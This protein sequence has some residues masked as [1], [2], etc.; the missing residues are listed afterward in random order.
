MSILFFFYKYAYI[1]KCYMHSFLVLVLDYLFVVILVL[2]DQ[3]IISNHL[4]QLCCGSTFAWNN[5]LRKCKWLCILFIAF[6]GILHRIQV[7]TVCH[8]K[9]SQHVFDGEY[10]MPV[11]P[12]CGA[13]PCCFCSRVK[14]LMK[15]GRESMWTCTPPHRLMEKAH[16]AL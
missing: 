2:I 3:N 7:L 12:I 15:A 11:W 4:W 16:T 13:C 1:F 9:L 6:K 10:W 14:V 5:F 8:Q